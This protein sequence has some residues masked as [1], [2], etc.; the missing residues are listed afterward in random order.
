[1][2]RTFSK[3]AEAAGVPAGAI[4]QIMG[5]QPSALAE[6]YRHREMDV[7][8]EYLAKAESFI[9]ERAGVVPHSDRAA[10]AANEFELGGGPTAYAA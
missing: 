1:M 4:A 9:L 2:R 7:L 6:R 8:A 5:H 10:E 3:L